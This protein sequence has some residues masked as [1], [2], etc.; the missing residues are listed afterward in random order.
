[1][2]LEK[3]SKAASLP[4]PGDGNSANATIGTVNTGNPGVQ[5]CLEL[6]KIQMS[7]F[8]HAGVIGLTNLC[9]TGGAGKG[10]PPCEIYGI[11]EKVSGKLSFD[12]VK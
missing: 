12:S 8:H 3:K 6:E 2:L 9:I 5:E 4:D 11:S 1:M 7:P 10:P